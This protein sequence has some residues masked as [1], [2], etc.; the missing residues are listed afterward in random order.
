[1]KQ[2]TKARLVSTSDQDPPLLGRLCA[3]GHR[4]IE[5]VL[6]VV[7]GQDGELH[8][9]RLGRFGG[10]GIILVGRWDIRGGLAQDLLGLSNVL[11]QRI[12]LRGRESGQ[13][14]DESSCGEAHCD[15]DVCCCCCCCGVG[16]ELSPAVYVYKSRGA[17]ASQGEGERKI[18]I[19]KQIDP[20]FTEI[21]IYYSAYNPSTRKKNEWKKMEAKEKLRDGGN[22]NLE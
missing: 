2:L 1:M 19:R 18:G 5:S 4:R 9:A 10:G 12:L 16:K 14:R 15:G 7:L 13:S 6:P 3:G 20:Q 21:V 17:K 8:G 11:V 22:V